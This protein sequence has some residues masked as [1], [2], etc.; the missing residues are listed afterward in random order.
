MMMGTEGALMLLALVLYIFD[1]TLLLGSD[2]WVL[3][4]RRGG[5][6]RARFGMQGWKL[7]GKEPLLP[8][9][10]TP[11]RALRRVQWRFEEGLAP[12]QAQPQPEGI[13]PPA[14][15]Q[16]SAALLLLLIFGALPM[17]LFAYPLL[18]L[19]VAVAAAIYA[20]CAF[21]ALLMWRARR[22]LS[23]QAADCAKLALECIACPP[24]A[25][26]IVRKLS[27]RSPSLGAGPALRLASDQQ[28]E[29]KRQMLARLQERIDFEAEESPRMARLQAAAATLAE[30]AAP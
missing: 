6:W 21:T 2:A 1:S 14:A 17:T 22:Q 26:N 28:A 18:L 16:F 13:T 3:E 19:K 27:L 20:A 25:I 24:F 7:A 11:W 5:R 12:L 4:A 9:P 8:N 29:A 10:L 30:G 15:L 23:L